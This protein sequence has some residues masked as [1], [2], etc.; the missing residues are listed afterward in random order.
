MK[1]M[2]GNFISWFDTLEELGVSLPPEYVFLSELE[3]KNSI[4][5]MADP[6]TDPVFFN[7]LLDGSGYHVRFVGTFKV[8][9][10]EIFNE[11][12]SII[13]LQ[14]LNGLGWKSLYKKEEIIMKTIKE[15]ESFILSWVLE[16]LE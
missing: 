3:P 11:N 9:G 14:N 1:N 13:I 4:D 2:D 8:K 15:L 6:I 12:N 5:S 7:E 10:A 16:H